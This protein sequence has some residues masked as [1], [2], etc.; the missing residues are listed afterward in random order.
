MSRLSVFWILLVLVALPGRPAA[1]QAP[2]GGD[3]LAFFVAKVEPLLVDHCY[4]CHGNGQLKGGLNFYTREALLAG[5]DSGP[6][7]NL[8]EPSKSLFLEA[9][10]YT[11]YEMPPNGKLPEESLRI[12]TQWVEMGAPMPTRTDVKTVHPTVPQVDDVTRQHW[13]FRAPSHPQVP[14]QDP[15]WGKNQIDAFVLKSLKSK[16]L[17]PN[18][19]ADRLT[20]IRRVA[21][22][23]TGLPPTAPE[24][25]MFLKDTQPDAYE[26]MVESYLASPHYGEHWARYWL[27]L[28]RY[29]ESNSFERDN[30]KPFVW[31]YRDY[32][33]RAFNDDKPYQQ[34]VLEQLA[35]DELPEPTPDS[36]IATGFYR[37]GPWDDEPA[38]PKQARYDELDDIVSTVGQGFLGLTLNCARCH[39]HKLD[40]ISQAD[41]YRFLA[42]FENIRRYGIRHEKS[43]YEASVREIATAAE[44]QAFQSEI[45]AYQQQLADLRSQLDAVEEALHPRLKGGERDDFQ[46]DSV[47][48]NILKKHV[49]DLLT[50]EEFQ[51]YSR[52]RKEWNKLKQNPVQSAA[53]ALCVK[54]SGPV[55]APTH[56]LIRGNPGAEG[57]V[58]E[59]QF[60]EIFG[61]PVPQIVVP[62]DQ[63]SSGRRLA[64]ARWITDPAN[65]LTA[66]VLVNRIWQWH[67]DDGL[68]RSPNNFGLTC[69]APTHPEL[70]DW[71]AHEFL[72]QGG[73]I[74]SLHR[75]IL[76][77]GTY[78][79][80]SLANPQA[81]A[82]DPE[83]LTN[84]RFKMRRLRAEEIRDSILFVNGTLRLDTLFG[85]S[86]YPKIPAAVLAGQS[87]PGENWPES[88][89]ADSCRRSIYIHVKR[90]LPLPLLA[91]F[92]VADSDF[93]CPVRFATTQPTQ[94]LGMLNS[95]FI[96]EQALIMHRDVVQTIGPD[97]QAQIKEILHRVT[98]RTPQPA[99]IQR[100]L[101][102]VKCLQNDYQQSADQA[103]TNFCLVALN[104]N[105]FLYLD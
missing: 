88:S 85:P 84:W 14:A 96:N 1:A 93:T 55:P 23:L 5:G 13:A 35:G 57:D 79:M 92:D 68:V 56:I 34:F 29:A 76:F 31:K 40:P 101:D 105:E 78:K 62:A 26:R 46:I 6:A 83:N 42:F 33:I 52:T 90:S 65:P 71:L 22:D 24:I 81:L 89:A 4:R 18:P 94:A 50:Q 97:P 69:D 32:V 11:T 2:A 12:L 9:I 37:L 15:H 75:L 95:D 61:S 98:Q 66:R 70:L 60:P 86:I 44:K 16:G 74:K 51:K 28:V 53:Q 38:D 63:L 73:S 8:E 17:P 64:L 41:Y 54:E 43:V 77:S 82:A 104:L 59:P 39:D 47:R 7:V 19:E 20:L 100:G 30:P 25:E 36:I 27:D 103:M 3:P 91:A 45:D 58:V 10:N 99:E 72:R 80:S 49:G 102:L 21:Y 48:E 67:F 87:R